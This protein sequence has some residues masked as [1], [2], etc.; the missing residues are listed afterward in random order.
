M[1]EM[2]QKTENLANENSKDLT[3]QW[4]QGELPEGWYY[5]KNESKANIDC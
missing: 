3:Q 5:V 1:T 4:K 2:L